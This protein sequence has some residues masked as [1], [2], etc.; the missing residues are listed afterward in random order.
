MKTLKA[1]RII[2]T[3]TL[4][5][6]G[7]LVA[8]TL[9][10]SQ[11]PARVEQLPGRPAAISAP[12]VQSPAALAANHH[13]V[14]LSLHLEAAHSPKLSNVAANAAAD[15][16][17]AL[18]NS[19]YLII[20]DGSQAATADTAISGQTTCAVLRFGSTAFGAASTGVSTA[21]TITSDT[22]ADATCTATWFRT[23]ES[24]NSTKVMDGTIG[25]SGADIN[26]AT[27]SI[28]QHATV[29]VSS[30]TYSQSKS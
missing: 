25:T 6:V 4:L 20:L 2:Y 14:T 11:A 28:S 1:I 26:L 17:T 5:A 19:G 29:S 8:S 27:V 15:A 7:A 9:L 10:P 3:T 21:N 16:F 30:F 24:D 23:L 12:M 22:D 13:A 18:L